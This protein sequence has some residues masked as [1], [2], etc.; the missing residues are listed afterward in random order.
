MVEYPNQV[1]WLVTA[2]NPRL[3]MEIARRSARIR[4]TPAEDRPWE[5]TEFKHHPIRQWALE[6]RPD[7]VYAVLVIVQSWN[8]AGR[9]AGKI[10]LGSFEN[11]A[12]VMGGILHHVGVKGFLEDTDEFYEAADLEGRE[13][14]AFVNAWWEKYGDTWVQVRDLWDLANDFDLIGFVLGHK[15]ERSQRTRL[16]MRLAG[17]R[18]RRFGDMRIVAGTD[19]HS[20]AAQYRLVVEAGDLF[21]SDGAEIVPFQRDPAGPQN[22]GTAQGTAAQSI[23]EE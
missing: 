14:R 9:P 18:D 3:S 12:A 5:R 7:L 6:N 16:G 15:G 20:K 23:E 8:A 13:W 10:T 2:N 19:S 21:G 17:M 11:W 22:Q 1:T 4:L